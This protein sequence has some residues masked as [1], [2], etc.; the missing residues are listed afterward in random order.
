MLDLKDFFAVDENGKPLE[1]P[2]NR[3][4]F[5]EEDIEYKLIYIKAMQDLGME[6]SIDRI[7]NICGTYYG[8]KSRDKSIICGSHTDSVDNGGQFD[9]PLGV[10]S[11]LKTAEDIKNSGTMP[12]INYKAI[13]YACEES[14]RFKGKAC[15]GSKYLRGDKTDFNAIISRDGLSLGEIVEQYKKEFLSRA[16]SMGLKPIKEVDKVIQSDEIVTAIESHIEQAD[17][18][19]NDGKDI[20][21][22]TSI[23]APYRLQARIDDIETA[24]KF[25]CDLE[26]DAKEAETKE[27]GAYRATVTEFSIKN[28]LPQNALDGKQIITLKANGKNNHSG[29]TPMGE[30]KDAV[31]GVA[32]LINALSTNKKETIDFIE[33]CTP[34]WGAN[35]ITDTCYVQ[36]AV[37]KITDKNGD[38]LPE[39]VQNAICEVGKKA[40]VTFDRLDGIN[41]KDDKKIETIQKNGKKVDKESN[42]FI[43]V[44]QQVGMSSKLTADKIWDTLLD[45]LKTTKKNVLLRPKVI[46]EPYSTNGELVEQAKKICEENGISY[47]IMKSWAGH[48]LATLTNNEDARTILVFGPNTGGS[49][50][51]HETTT[52]DSIK[53]VFLVQSLLVK[54][55]LERA[56]K[57]EVLKEDSMMALN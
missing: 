47:N 9:G 51:P 42:L 48:D 35:Q 3:I 50:N 7:G 16:N 8:K 49:H 6:V 14:T 18:L 25:I 54:E 4:A 19:V 43:D 32:S 45:I 31:Y 40:N 52:L 55:E 30:R 24:A 44:R 46:G 23:V 36:F 13:I 10:F 56:G 28:D 57:K 2:I 17:S 15:L 27:K 5:T 38:I 53:K 34:N 21:I 20:G 41:V 29:A 1:E 39:F 37:P 22:C 33:A 11:A 26:D 12:D